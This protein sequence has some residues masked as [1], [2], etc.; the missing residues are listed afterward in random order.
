MVAIMY[1][2]IRKIYLKVGILL[3]GI[4]S[5]QINQ[6]NTTCN[7]VSIIFL[8][9]NEKE[10]WIKTQSE[11][12]EF[13]HFKHCWMNFDSTLNYTFIEGII[14]HSILKI[15]NWHI[16]FFFLSKNIHRNYELLVK[17]DTYDN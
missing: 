14:I 3:W 12:N 15:S 1:R 16:E 8:D 6:N 13:K 17:R 11:S 7:R 9:T 4:Q 10:F 5:Y 2:K